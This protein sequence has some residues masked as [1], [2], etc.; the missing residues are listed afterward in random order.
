M[1]KKEKD[2]EALYQQMELLYLQIQEVLLHSPLIAEEKMAVMMRFN[3]ELLRL[4]RGNLVEM[5]VSDGSKISV[6][7]ELPPPLTH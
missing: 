3:F 7:L 4:S 5:Q 1:N 6:K 2:N